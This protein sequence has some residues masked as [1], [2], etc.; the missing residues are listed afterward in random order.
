[1][2]VGKMQ[3]QKVILIY[4]NSRCQILSQ[5]KEIK[6]TKKWK[7]KSETLHYGIQCPSPYA[8]FVLH[9]VLNVVVHDIRN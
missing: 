7:I 3:Q 2:H 6:G 5:Y 9:I 8:L 1:M 4:L